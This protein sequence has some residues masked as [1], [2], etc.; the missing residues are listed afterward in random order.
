MIQ[1]SAFS[2]AFR[3]PTSLESIDL[4]W[5]QRKENIPKPSAIFRLAVV[6]FRRSIKER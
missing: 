1:E 2:T 6:S 5:A 4:Q 3:G